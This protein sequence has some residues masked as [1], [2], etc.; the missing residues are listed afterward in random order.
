MAT[1]KKTGQGIKS[2]VK[3][4][5][6]QQFRELAK[7]RSELMDLTS[8]FE[9]DMLAALKLGDDAEV[10]GIEEMVDYYA[11]DFFEGEDSSAYTEAIDLLAARAIEDAED[12][13]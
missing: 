13:Q 6:C 12:S 2:E 7:L 3:A 1:K 11:G 5:L 8:Q 9:K 10:A 4:K